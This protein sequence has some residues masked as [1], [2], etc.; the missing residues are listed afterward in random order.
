MMSISNDMSF[1]DTVVPNLNFTE[2]CDCYL[3]LDSDLLINKSIQVEV[4]TLSTI[5]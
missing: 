4:S 1:L 5:N 3:C 2:N